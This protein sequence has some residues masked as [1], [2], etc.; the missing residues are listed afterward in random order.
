VKTFGTHNYYVYILTNKNHQ[1]LYIG[2]TNELRSRIQQHINDAQT[3]KKTFA[4]RYNCIHL[5]YY[6]RFDNVNDAIRR[7]KELKGWKRERKEAL[8][9][10]VNPNWDFIVEQPE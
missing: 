7:E 3:V 8:I 1:V 9:N 4:G 5:V 10:A 2:V 6:E